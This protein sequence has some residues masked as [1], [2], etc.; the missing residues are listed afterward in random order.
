L[1]F[2]PFVPQKDK[3]ALKN[4]QKD[5]YSYKFKKR[6]KKKKKKTNWLQPLGMGE[7]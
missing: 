6:K 4:S 2:I 5:K 7:H 3:N 1:Q